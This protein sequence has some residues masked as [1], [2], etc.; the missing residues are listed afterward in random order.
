MLAWL[1]AG[2]F[3]GLAGGLATDIG[4]GPPLLLMAA[5]VC[6]APGRLTVSRRGAALAAAGANG[7]ASNCDA[8][9]CTHGR[10]AEL[11]MDEL[12]MDELCMDGGQTGGK[13]FRHPIE[14]LEVR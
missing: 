8:E 10:D 6:A 13:S 2:P 4:I 3:G 14:P 11:C 1:P 5:A 7:C 12:C 9:L